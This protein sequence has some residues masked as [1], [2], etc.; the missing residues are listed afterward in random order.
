MPDYGH[1]IRFGTFITPT[2]AP[3]HQAVDL[4]L[5]SERLDYDLVTFQDHPYQ[6]GFHDTWTLLTWVAARTE[7][8]H[9]AGNVL[10]TPLR[11]PAVLARSAASLDLL[12]GG[13]LELGLGAGAFW[14]P[15]A[16]MGGPEWTPGQAVDALGEAID[17]IRGIWDAGDRSPLRVPGAFYQVDG[18]KRGPLPAH[19]IPIWLGA[20]KPRMLGLIGTKADGWLPSLPYM[21]P[22]DQDRGNALI[23]DA[24]IAAGRDPRE[25]TRLLN[26]SGNEPAEELARL[27]VEDGVSVFIVIGDSPASIERFAAESAP[28]I[29]AAVE[30]ARQ[31][32]GTPT[33][34]RIRGGG[35]LGKRRDGI[36]YDAVPDSLRDDAIEPG[37]FGYAGASANYLR[38]GAPGLILRPRDIAE[39]Q[40]AVTFASRHPA[41]ELGIRSAG[42]GV[43][44]RSTND[45]GIVIDLARLDEIEVLDPVDGLV[46]I[47]PGATWMRVAQA[48]SPHGLAITSGDYGGVGVG[49]LA[50]GGGVGWFARE[51]GLTIDHLR[52]VD[53]VLADGSLVR[54]SADEHPDLFWAMRGAGGNVGIGV[55]FDF[56]AQPT[57][58][59]AFAQFVFDASDTA[60]FVRGWGDV[61]EA[62]PRIVSGQF[63]LG[64]SSP[65]RATIAQAMLVVDSA[66]PDD[67]LEALQPFAAV[68]P[69][70]DQ[71]ISLGSYDQVMSLLHQDLPHQGRGE[72][73]SRSALV[74][75]LDEG[76]A[77]ASTAVIASGAAA[78][79][80]I[81]S[82]G[83]AVADVASEATAY[84]G[85]D[86][87][88]SIVALGSSAARLDAAWAPLE[89]LSVG[90]YLS[91]DTRQG[92]E[93]VQR[94]FPP[95]HLARLR[96][97][98]ARLDPTGRFRDNFPVD[99]A[100]RTLWT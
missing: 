57:G 17:I 47:G 56:Q 24:A 97:I 98:K 66:N 93:V 33:G 27:A 69:L 5:L 55:S 59:V 4:A 37:D 79:F 74:A 28:A 29:R 51:H 7:R 95:A 38:G 40:T 58:N 90:M 31:V 78:F 30:R 83:G 14:G 94:A 49:G 99:V 48:L 23:D 19:A 81:R 45:G 84:A 21:K 16:A 76:V 52:A 60:G 91:F 39:V 82:V 36:D 96:E 61:M 53:V 9:L 71:S 65:G 44:G 100:E 85:R 34:A 10:S 25:I 42:H 26:V 87:A 12:S 32:T 92:P 80:Q 1:P 11:Q 2:N 6:P 63:L 41:I 15:I 3:A 22:G 50:T 18:A 73:V 54:A 72:P 67:V 68:G 88:F 35:A 62:A 70:L 43:S 46:R 86:A 64:A 8:I 13:R 77:A 20:Y 89:R 75:H